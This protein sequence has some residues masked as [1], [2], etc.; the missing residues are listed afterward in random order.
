MVP[1]S[2]RKEIN[3]KAT[4]AC[5]GPSPR[6]RSSSRTRCRRRS[7]VID[8]VICGWAKTWDS[9]TDAGDAAGAQ[10]AAAAMTTLAGWPAIDQREMS[11]SMV[12]GYR[13]MLDEAAS[14]MTAGRVPDPS[15][16]Q[17]EDALGCE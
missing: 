14:E 1:S 2:S 11:P 15:E 7:V 13:R 8:S 9:A 3:A 5:D 10:E 12:P 17:W 6:A 16:Q 4:A